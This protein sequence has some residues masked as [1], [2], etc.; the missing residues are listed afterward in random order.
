MQKKYTKLKSQFFKVLGT[1]ILKNGSK[2]FVK[3]REICI[4]RFD[5]NEANFLFNLNRVHFSEIFI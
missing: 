4:D 1:I 2:M 5:R 3:L